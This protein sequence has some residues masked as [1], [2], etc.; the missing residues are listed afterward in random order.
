M[1]SPKQIQIAASNLRLLHDAE[2]VVSALNRA[3]IQPVLLKGTAFLNSGIAKI[4]DRLMDDVDL[5]IP[6]ADLPV[7]Y[8]AIVDAGYTEPEA[9]SGPFSLIENATSGE[10]RFIGGSETTIELHYHLIA[11]EWLIRVFPRFDEREIWSRARPCTFGKAVAR[12]LSPEDTLLHLCLHLTVHHYTHPKGFHDIQRL[13]DPLQ[14]F[15]WERFLLLVQKYQMGA[16]VYF[17]LSTATHALGASVPKEVLDRVQP[18]SFRRRLVRWIADP[19]KAL[20]GR[21]SLSN[22]RNYL[23]HMAIAE[24][25]VDALRMLAWL[26]FPGPAWLQRHYQLRGWPSAGLAC[27][28]HPLVVVSKGLSSFNSVVF[29]K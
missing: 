14:P 28:W 26:F 22:E 1:L 15:P 19:Y 25:P 13:I 6:S 21:L 9:S 20:S 29:Q 17:P 10:I 3:G 2:D 27:L 16:L 23:L 4:D 18:G 7:A 5:W 8:Q 11:I 12:Q 24:N